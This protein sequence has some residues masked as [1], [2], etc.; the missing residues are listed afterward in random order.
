MN[1]EKKYVQVK[2]LEKHF[3][4]QRYLRAF[5]RIFYDRNASVSKSFIAPGIPL[6]ACKTD[7]WMFTCVLC[8]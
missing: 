5:T 6:K 3:N 2:C 7:L 4:H 8:H 1:S